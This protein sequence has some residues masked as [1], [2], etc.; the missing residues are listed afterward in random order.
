MEACWAH[1]PEVRAS[2]PHSANFFYHKAV[3]GELNF[4]VLVIFLV[5]RFFVIWSTRDVWK[6]SPGKYI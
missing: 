6:L 4:A 2:K 3:Y 5:F 1:N